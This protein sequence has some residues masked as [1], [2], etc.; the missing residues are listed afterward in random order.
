MMRNKYEGAGGQFASESS[1]ILPISAIGEKRKTPDGGYGYPSSENNGGAGKSPL[2]M[3]DAF[4]DDIAKF[5]YGDTKDVF[6][7]TTSG[8]IPKP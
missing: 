2:G 3:W 8:V 4:G 5:G 7:D 1:R 6:L